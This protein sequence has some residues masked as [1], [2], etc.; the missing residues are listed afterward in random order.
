MTFVFSSIIRRKV[1]P[2]E[3]QFYRHSSKFDRLNWKYLGDPKNSADIRENI[4]RRKGVGDIDEVSHLKSK[5]DC[6][7]SGEKDS[8]RE[9]LLEAALRIPNVSHSSLIH[10]DGSPIVVKRCGTRKNYDFRPAAFETL[11]K[12]W[13]LT[14]TDT[15]VYTGP[16]SYY[17]LDQLADLEA[18]LVN[19]A[20][21]L[22]RSKGFRLVSVPDVLPREVIEDCGMNTRGVRSQ[23]YSLGGE[24]SN[25]DLC[26]SGTAEMGV[27]FLLK[28]QELQSK[29]FPQ[30]IA[31]VSRCYRA[32]TS[33]IS[34]EKGIYRVHQF[35]KVEMYGVYLP[36]ESAEGLLHFRDIQEEFFNSLGLEIQI[37]DM[38]ECELGAQA[39]RK[40]DIE[41]YFPGKDFWGELS[42]ASDCTDY[43]ARRLNITYDSGK[44]PH[45]ING[46]LA[47]FPEP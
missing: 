32:E 19:Y 3:V 13:G 34:E 25:E 28:D 12:R 30:R 9:R 1:S 27:S 31:A 4:S 18:A 26:L 11:S 38:P 29:D 6:A 37:L 47:L 22:L 23:V 36:E 10:N 33:K 17:L 46:Q 39:H 24:L 45:T 5:Y 2:S 44:F 16:R 42:S 40:Y 35:T 14:R 41:A 43:Q 15:S 8:I 20:V 7:N 21:D